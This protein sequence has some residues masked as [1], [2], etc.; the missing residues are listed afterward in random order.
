MTTEAT[1]DES[2]R[3]LGLEL[4]SPVVASASPLGR[5]LDSLR[6]LEAAGAG[7]VVLP[8]LYEE[9]IREDAE[10]LVMLLHQGAG[11]F[12]EAATYIPEVDEYRTGPAPYLR[13]LEATVDALSIPVIG[14][15]N[16]TTPGGW[17]EYAAMMADSGAAAIELNPYAVA[18]DASVEPGEYERRLVELTEKVVA[19]VAIPVSVK[20]SPWWSALANLADSLVAAG[21]CG[22]V[23]FNRFVQPD[24]DLDTLEVVDEV[25]LS[26]PSEIL[27]PLRWTGLL[28][29][30]LDC[31]IA[32]SGGVHDGDGAAK[33]LLA[34]ADVA[35]TTSALLRRGPGH[36][37]TIRRE[38]AERLSAHGY[39]STDQARGAMSAG[40][41]PDPD[42][43]ERAKYR[44]ALTSY[45]DD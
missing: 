17:T 35:M 4:G 8:S 33:A 38:L 22:L 41:V 25:R 24:I 32:L 9:E 39:E 27:L 6:D 20:L 36:V 3:Y 1:F 43:F 37:A 2:T 13:H 34:G 15:L 23:L 16:G 29:D 40:K 26:N 21:A 30:R 42:A 10:T 31:S 19:T 7:A 45:R 14:S 18:A 44:H 11:A 28:R 5:D 12:V